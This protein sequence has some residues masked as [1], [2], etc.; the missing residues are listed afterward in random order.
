MK[1][2]GIVVGGIVL[3]VLVLASSGCEVSYRGDYRD[4]RGDDRGDRGY[5]FDRDGNRHERYDQRGDSR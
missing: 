3:A 4:R 2:F 1:R 5:W